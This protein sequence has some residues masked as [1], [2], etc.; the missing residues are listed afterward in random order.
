MTD[1]STKP[2]SSTGQYVPPSLEV[3]GPVRSL[4]L[5]G[6]TFGSGDAMWLVIPGQ[7]VQGL[8]N[9]SG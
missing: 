9:A 1:R 3:L 6:K 4:T 5:Q 7:P 8:M 2:A